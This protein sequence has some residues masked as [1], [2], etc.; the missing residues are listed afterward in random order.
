MKTTLSPQPALARRWRPRF[1]PATLLALAASAAIVIS[2]RLTRPGVAERP[3]LQ[4]GGRPAMVAPLWKPEP[5]MLLRSAGALALTKHQHVMIAAADREWKAS[6]AALLTEADAAA[7]TATGQATAGPSNRPTS[8]I[9]VRQK[10]AAY[11]EVSR[12]IDIGREERWLAALGELSGRQ[13][14][15]VDAL[16]SR[17]ELR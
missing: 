4:Q 12:R 3:R 6:R 2:G 9:E 13:R 1:G 10:L 7:A 14:A 5:A 15:R 11:S 16:R 8:I 17:G